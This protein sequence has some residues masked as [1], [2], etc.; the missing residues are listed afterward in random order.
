MPGEVLHRF[1]NVA[2]VAGLD[3]ERELLDHLDAAPIFAHCL[4]TY[5]FASVCEELFD[6]H[7][8]LMGVVQ[9]NGLALNQPMFHVLRHA[10]AESP[11]DLA[12]FESGAQSFY[13]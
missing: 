4:G 11:L 10:C 2:E 7:A 6:S 12:T 5:S 9:E 3:H 8:Q 1:D 13:G